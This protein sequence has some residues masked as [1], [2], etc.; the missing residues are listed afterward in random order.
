MDYAWN[1]FTGLDTPARSV[2]PTL[3]AEMEREKALKENK[4][5]AGNA[6]ISGL[7]AEEMATYGRVLKQTERIALAEYRRH[8][9][10]VVPKLSLVTEGTRDL[11]A[12]ENDV[13]RKDRAECIPCCALMGTLRMAPPVMLASLALGYTDWWYGRVRSVKRIVP[14][15]AAVAIPF[16]A[17]TTAGHAAFTHSLYSLK[18][19]KEDNFARGMRYYAMGAALV[20][21]PF[22]GYHFVRHVLLRDKR[23]PAA[24]YRAKLRG[25]IVPL[26]KGQRWGLWK[27]YKDGTAFEYGMLILFYALALPMCLY[28]FAAVY[29]D[30]DGIFL[31]RNNEFVYSCI[32]PQLV[33]MARQRYIKDTASAIQEAE[34]IEKLRSRPTSAKDA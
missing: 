13:L 24:V 19:K 32:P 17:T 28:G 6:A 29:H 26:K 27:H 30:G 34:E 8:S 15:V 23:I 25:E 33:E 4:E 9:G 18:P 31:L 3:R 20:S 1:W 16:F 14:F 10:S 12:R 11:V 7:E 22:F 2:N 21:V 5:K